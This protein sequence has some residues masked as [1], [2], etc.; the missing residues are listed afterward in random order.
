MRLPAPLLRFKSNVYKN[1]FGHLFI[2]AGSKQMVGAGAL[3]SLAA[4][5]SGAGLV[6]LGVPKSLNAVAQKKIS[7]VVMTFPLEETSSQTLALSCFGQIQNAY[8]NYQAIALGPGLSQNPNT[9]KLILKIIAT[10]P[11]PLV[12]DA[13]ALNALNG[14]LRILKKTRTPKILTPHPGEMARL[15]NVKK[16][17]IEKNRSQIA[18]IFAKKYR[19]TVLLKG[20]RTIVA[21]LNGKIDINKTGNAGMATAGSGDVLTGIIAAFIGQGLSGFEAAKYG[22]YLHGRAGDLAAKAKTRLAMT[23]EDMIDYIPKAVKSL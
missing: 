8:S 10:S 21:S 19:C 22:A 4:M 20:H 6:T 11:L 9:K 18:K 16:D 23:A 5:R 13:D 17:A 15:I 1:T 12:I 2:L 14:N 3:C 7:N